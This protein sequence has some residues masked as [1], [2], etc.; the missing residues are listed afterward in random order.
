MASP[1]VGAVSETIISTDSN[2]WTVNRPAGVSGRL[3]I[4][5]AGHDGNG[6]TMTWPTGYT[7]FF[8]QDNTGGVLG[9]KGA[10]HLEDGTEGTT[11]ILGLSAA[12]KG[13]CIVYQVSGAET[14]ATQ[15]PE[16]TTASAGATLDPDCPAITPTGGSK[17]Y[18]F[19]AG[20]CTNGEEADDDTWGN[21][22][23]TNYSP[24]PPRQKTSGI[25]GTPTTNCCL[26]TAER[27]LTAATEDPGIFNNDQSLAYASFTIAVHP[28]GGAIPSA[29][30]V[31]RVHARGTAS[32]SKIGLGLAIGRAGIR[33]T[34]TG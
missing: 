31:G 27:A 13:A 10:Y 7:Q 4:A 28:A 20:V 34:A 11:F 6:I 23:P 19:I 8:A 3:T 33:G 29:S 25:A 9:V 12:E 5:I 26:E 1:V 15:V 22:S 17:D 2:S 18:L 16:A 14:P 30:G 32:G 21:T 24:S